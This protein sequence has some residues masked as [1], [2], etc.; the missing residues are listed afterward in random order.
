MI[1]LLG[2]YVNRRQEGEEDK[3]AECGSDTQHK[4][5][6]AHQVIGSVPEDKT[7]SRANSYRSMFQMP[8][9]MLEHLI[10]NPYI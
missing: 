10:L 7:N 5:T 2:E 8:H 1:G 6:F 9:F 4:S 3:T